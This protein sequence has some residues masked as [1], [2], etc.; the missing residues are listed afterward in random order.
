MGRLRQYS[1]VPIDPA[2]SDAHSQFLDWV[3]SSLNILIGQN[4]SGSGFSSLNSPTV[5]PTSSQITSKGSRTSSLT[6]P[7]Y[8]KANSP[9]SIT[10]YW[11]GTNGS[12]PLKIYRDDGS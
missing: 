7:F 10:L 5:D 6:T 9:T 2:I 1:Q 11:D 3:M 4:I 12:T 8:A